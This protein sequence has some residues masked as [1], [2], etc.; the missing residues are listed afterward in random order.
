MSHKRYAAA[1]I[2][3]SLALAACGGDDDDEPAAEPP[4]EEPAEEPADEPMEE[5]ADEP[6]EE[7]AG[8]DL[9]TLSGSI[10][11]SGSSTVE[12]I[13]IAAGNAFA[14][15]A[16]NVAVTVEGPGTG[17]GFALFCA[18]ETD[19]SDASRA[20][21]DEEMADCEANGIEFIELKVAVDGLSPITSVENTAVECLSFV[22][23]YALLGPDA[24]GRNNWSDA[25]AQADEIAATVTD[26]GAVN[27]PYPD[28]SLAVTAPGEESGTF[29]FFLEE[30]IEGV[31]EALGAEDANVRPDYTASPNDNVII[32]GIAS[33][34]T[35]LGWVGFAFVEEN[36]DSIKP[37]QVDGG[38]GCIE[39]TPETIASGEFPIARPLFIYAS[40]PALE[41]NAA[42]APFVDF[43]VGEALTTLIGAEE[44][45]V[46]YVPLTDEGVAATQGVWEA[47]E[48]GTREG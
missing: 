7:P 10:F 30:V 29:D 25:T 46:P 47:R 38:A 3:A 12:P 16:P 41:S 32:E 8:E 22:D 21:K 9:S 44:G 40:V 6:M 26:L 11:V 34:P 19:V 43:Y 15:L 33:N 5:P 39:P 28:A 48:T 27:T 2:V 31:G 20:I 4:A 37:L 17:D 24:T 13:S 36:L 18:G 42:L 23:L 45:Q 1:A 14:D 35:S